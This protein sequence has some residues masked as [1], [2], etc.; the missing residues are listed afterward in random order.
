MAACGQKYAEALELCTSLRVLTPI[1]GESFINLLIFILTRDELKRDPRLYEDYRRKEIDIRVKLLAHN[2]IG[3]AKPVDEKAG[4]F[5]DFL[6]LMNDRND[7]LHGNTDPSR[8]SFQTVY[9]DHMIPLFPAQINFA[10]AV[11]KNSLVGIEPSVVLDAVQTIRKFID[12]ILSLLEKDVRE[13]VQMFMRTR[14]LGWRPATKRIGIL[15]VPTMVEGYL[16]HS[17][18][19]K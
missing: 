14:D 7:L 3:F 19:K 13:Q 6:R 12:Y 5:R 11:L 10:G 2:C 18:A 15:F 1:W 17:P 9:F 8:L 4:E 16:R